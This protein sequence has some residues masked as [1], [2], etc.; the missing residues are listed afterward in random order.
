M[1]PEYLTRG[2]ISKK[3]DIFSLGVI[4]IE[5]ITGHKDYPYFQLDSPESTATSCQHFTEEVC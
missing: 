5:I 4:I 1:A 2:L 3:A